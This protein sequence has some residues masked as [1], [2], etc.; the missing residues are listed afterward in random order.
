MKTKS[1][2]NSRNTDQLQMQASDWS[3]EVTVAQ[4]LQLAIRS[5]EAG[6]LKE[7]EQVCSQVLGADPDN[8]DAYHL[9]GAIA[10]RA[11]K[12]QLAIELFGR[13]IE[14]APQNA[15]VHFNLGSVLKNLGNLEQAGE[16]FAEAVELRPDY[17]EAHNNLGAVLH[18]LMRPHDAIACF[19]K[20][21]AFKPEYVMAHFN[22]GGALEQVG[23]HEDAAASFR[24][25]ISLKPEFA[26]A[27]RCLGEIMMRL[28]RDEEA[29][30]ALKTAVS[31]APQNAQSQNNL[32]A[33]QQRLGLLDDA[34]QSFTTALSIDPHYAN[35]NN[36]LGAAMQRLGRLDDA[37]DC[38]R[39]ALAAKPDYPE[40]QNN[41]GAALRDSGHLEQAVQCFRKALEKE[42]EYAEAYNNL[43][44][45]LQ[46]L[47]R[48][49][50]AMECFQAALS[51]CSTYGDAQFNLSGALKRL[52]RLDEAA[53]SYRKT[54]TLDPDN[55]EAHRLLSMI[56][57][58]VED[59]EAIAAMEGLYSQAGVSDE[60]KM[61][62]AFGLSK[63]YEAK[64]QYGKVFPY[65]RAANSIRRRSYEYSIADDKDHL[66]RIKEVFSARFFERLGNGGCTD[67]TP[68]FILGMPRSGTTLVEQILA[69]HSQVFGA[70]ELPD[71]ENL[72]EDQCQHR[73]PERVLEWGGEELWHLGARY[74]GRVRRH[75]TTAT[76]IT[77]KLPANF[78]FLGLIKAILPNASVIH[79]M[80]DPMDNCY[81]IY[82]HYFTGLKKYTND[83][84]E[85]GRY[86]T[87]YADLMDHWRETIPEFFF[88]LQ[89][90]ELVRDQ[91]SLTRELLDF[92]GLP[93]EPACL[94]FHETKRDV[95]T[96]SAVQVRRPMNSD[97]VQLW[98]H[99]E[100][101]LQP[102]LRILREAER[103]PTTK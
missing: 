34:V 60:Q 48:V 58:R 22:L 29:L 10:H 23:R 14:A 95:A 6:Q 20:A 65:L 100:N 46:D 62:L 37:I 77:D 12:S 43:G 83:L 19:A 18:A 63:A 35:A 49:E 69:S 24:R 16:A 50:S 55:A 94:S 44:A 72:V 3:G 42:P 36:N 32:G 71:L 21:V 5:Y 33:V 99:Y 64:K 92:C 85:L 68:I 75:S 91:E 56:Q 90:E 101:E 70:G 102:L 93:W 103:Y 78:L 39:R 30:A 66:G 8:P 13:S 86:Y 89:Y 27:H 88:D 45:T 28:H 80:R 9:L 73:F 40:A 97:S 76:Y 51:I 57:E 26:E 7:A 38:Y 67:R 15:E 53:E 74:V 2:E 41:L 59:D 84:E 47:G 87:Y 96:A 25:A 31:L 54:I 79:C 81:S 4:A 82:K 1:S 61:H 11:G 17:A 52:G 98:K